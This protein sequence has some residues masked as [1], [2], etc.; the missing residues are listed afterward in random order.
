[1]TQVENWQPIYQ[2]LAQ[3]IGMT[4]TQKL[5]DYFGGSQINFPKR[6]WQQEREADQIW[7]EYQSGTDVATLAR[8]H[9]YSSRT[10][11]RVLE[12][13]GND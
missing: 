5:C 9:Q 7:Q 2:E 1:M 4:A 13:Y 6:L 8:N 3:V 12:K 10:I 11:R